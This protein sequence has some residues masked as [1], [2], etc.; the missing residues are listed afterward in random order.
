VLR[1]LAQRWLAALALLLVLPGVPELL[2]AL[3]GVEQP[4]C[5]LEDCGDEHNGDR[6]RR[7]QALSRDDTHGGRPDMPAHPRG[8]EHSD[9]GCTHLRSHCS[10]C[11]QAGAVA[12]AALELTPAPRVFAAYAAASTLLRAEG[13]GTP[14]LRPPA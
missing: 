8:D 10:C 13:Y 14:P 1:S 6:T 12:R 2:R 5:P 11:P 9:E 3:S 4:C 7:A